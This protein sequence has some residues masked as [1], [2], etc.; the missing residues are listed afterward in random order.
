M[1]RGQCIILASHCVVSYL[2]VVM[3]SH[4]CAMPIQGSGVRLCYVMSLYGTGV[5]ISCVMTIL[6][7]YGQINVAIPSHLMA[8]CEKIDIYSVLHKKQDRR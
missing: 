6:V 8:L 5:T 2:C 1:W 7:W 4:C 3:V